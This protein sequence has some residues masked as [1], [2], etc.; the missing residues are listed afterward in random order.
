MK[1]MPIVYVT[2]MQRSVNFYRALTDSLVSQSA[3][4]SEFLVGD[5]HLALHF[6]DKLPQESRLELSFLADG[7]L[8]QVAAHLQASGLL[9]EREITDEAFGRSLRILD[10]DGLPIQINEHDSDLHP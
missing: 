2:E 5:S 7:T 1:L 9:L 10:P 8:E 4:W 3:Y 6:V